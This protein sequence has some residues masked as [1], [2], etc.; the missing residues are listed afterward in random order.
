MKIRAV[1]HVAVV[2]ADLKKAHEFYG[3]LLGLRKIE[4]PPE[5]KAG[6][7]GAWYQLDG[8]QLHLFVE[9]NPVST[10]PRHFGVEIEDF[11][12]IVQKLEAK[13]VPLEDAYSFGEFKRRK[14]TRD[15]SGNLV[16]LMSK[17]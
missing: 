4:R 3:E 11:D 5:V 16:E 17:T 15:P 2:V 1:N 13:G 14:F 12:E 8:L 6:G 10:I 9:S 7:P